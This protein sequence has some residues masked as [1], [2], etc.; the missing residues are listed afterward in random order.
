MFKNLCFSIEMLHNISMRA[1]DTQYAD[2]GYQ[3]DKKKRYPID[4]V[5]HIRAAWSYIHKEKNRLFYTK[6]QLLH[7]EHEIVSAW[8]EHIDPDGPP[9]LKK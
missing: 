8:K 7:I 3:K 6:D 1:D 2:P 9:S 5:E 4:T